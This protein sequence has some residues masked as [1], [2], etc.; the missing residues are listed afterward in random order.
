MAAGDSSYEHDH[1]RLRILRPEL[2]LTQALCPVCAVSYEEVSEL[3]AELLA[4][5]LHPDLVALGA[6]GTL[7][8][9]LR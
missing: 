7:E 6:A 4:H 3:A 9:D 1:D 2:I 5:I 8:V